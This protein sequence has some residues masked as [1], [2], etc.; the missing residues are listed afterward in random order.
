MTAP[1]LQSRA[2]LRQADRTATLL[3]LWED[4]S[5]RHEHLGS[6]RQPGQQPSTGAKNPKKEP[7][8]TDTENEK[9][10][11]ALVAAV[12]NVV[13]PAADAVAPAADVV[14]PVPDLVAPAPMS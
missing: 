10:G 7:G 13:P 3:T 14:A 4:D 2:A 5:G 1:T 11:S 8:D 12:P 6:G 9:K